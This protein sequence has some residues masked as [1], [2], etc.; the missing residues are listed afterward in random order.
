MKAAHVRETATGLNKKTGTI[1]ILLFIVLAGIIGG[2]FV[3]QQT[4]NPQKNAAEPSCPLNGF[5]CRWHRQPGVFYHYT[6]KDATGTLIKE[7]DMPASA[8]TD[9][10]TVTYTPQSGTTYTCGVEAEND[11]GSVNIEKTASCISFP[12]STLV[13]ESPM[14]SS[15][16]NYEALPSLSASSSSLAKTVSPTKMSTLSDIVIVNATNTPKP[17]Q[18][19]STKGTLTSSPT[20]KP[21][22]PVTGMPSLPTL[23][24]LLVGFIIMT[25]GLVL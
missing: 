9:I 21:T 20:K 22:L 19:N 3:V 23:T 6:I 17:S 15:Y 5:I 8:G 25:L 11:C 13:P 2:Y 4:Q 7:G 16:E 24:L 14:P 18:A 12:Q 1:L 10:I